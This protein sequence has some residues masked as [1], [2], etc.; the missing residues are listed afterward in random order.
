MLI[1]ENASNYSNNLSSFQ[2]FV[3]SGSTTVDYTF[4]WPAGPEEV[5]VTGE[6]DE[7]KGTMPLLK[8]SSGDFELTFPVKIPADKDRVFFKFIVDGTW[9]ASDAY[10]KGADE[11]GIENNYIS[12]NE[13]LALSE[14]PVGTK[15]PEAGGLVCRTTD[16]AVADD[17]IP[18]PGAYPKTPAD[19]KS[20]EARSAASKDAPKLEPEAIVSIPAVTG[21]SQVQEHVTKKAEDAENP[22]NS[23][24]GT[25][26]TER[27]ERSV[28]KREESIE[29]TEKTERPEQSVEKSV[30]S[31]EKAAKSAEKSAKFAEKSAKSAE[32]SVKSAEKPEQSAEKVAGT[33][34]PEQAG[35]PSRTPVAAANATTSAPAPEPASVP[36]PVKTTEAEGIKGTE[37][38]A[39]PQPAAIPSLTVKTTAPGDSNA[40]LTPSGPSDKDVVTSTITSPPRPAGSTAISEVTGS[41]VAAK[42]TALDTI[43]TVSSSESKKRF[44]IKRRFKKNKITGEKTIVSE[45]RVPLDSEESGTEHPLVDEELV[46]SPSEAAAGDVHIMPVGPPIQSENM[47]FTSLAGEPGPVV[48]GNV[49][50]VKEFTEVRNVDVDELNERLNK[51]EREKEAVVDQTEKTS[52]ADAGKQGTLTL[53][54]KTHQNE[55]RPQTSNKLYEVTNGDSEHVKDDSDAKAAAIPAAAPAKESEPSSEKPATTK[56]E[57]KPIAQKTSATA[58]KQEEKKKK[59]G[60]FS[61]LKKI[62]H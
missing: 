32:K 31:A 33:G 55:L 3:M 43:P 21:T 16:S 57:K 59:G 11:N 54:P 24:E 42:D 5:L 51:Q 25:E 61:K 20:E 22:E 37:T 9:L 62:F 18:E 4:E 44:K 41:T 29:G 26:K 2:K 34:N 15:I 28:E 38:A 27:A 46:A 56:N 39:K 13:A 52:P 48:P 8:T 50:E 49:A 30:E 10:T 17:A 53:D 60:F 35:E 58:P 19:G 12:R 14:N 45:E 6:F 40:N 1:E 7:W 36:K 47:K 23:T